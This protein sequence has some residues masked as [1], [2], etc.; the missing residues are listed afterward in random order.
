MTGKRKIKYVKV[1]GEA[2]CPSCDANLEIEIVP[3]LP[4][5]PKFKLRNLSKT[6]LK[7]F[8]EDMQCFI[9]SNIDCK[10]PMASQ[11]HRDMLISIRDKIIKQLEY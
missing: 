4:L 3:Y 11:H 5:I 9:D 1:A 10:N 2:N 6:N 7:K 8:L